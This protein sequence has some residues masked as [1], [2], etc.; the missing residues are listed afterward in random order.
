MQKLSQ[1]RRRKFLGSQLSFIERKLS[2]YRERAR[3][4]RAHLSEMDRVSHSE[5]NMAKV[6]IDVDEGAN[7]QLLESFAGIHR[8]QAEASRLIKEIL[9]GGLEDSY[10]RCSNC[11]EWIPRKRLKAIPWATMCV[12]CKEAARTAE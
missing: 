8:E 10:G 2:E 1:A 6:V 7:A 4:L 5:R 3:Q 11:G 12:S 9:F